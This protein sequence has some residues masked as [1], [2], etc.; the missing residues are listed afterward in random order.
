MHVGMGEALMIE[1]IFVLGMVCDN[2]G[3]MGNQEG[4]EKSQMR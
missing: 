4:N 2:S 3:R 1:C